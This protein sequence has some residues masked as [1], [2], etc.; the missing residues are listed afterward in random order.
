MGTSGAALVTPW[1]AEPKVNKLETHL[2]PALRHTGR[3][4]ETL[5]G[6]ALLVRGRTRGKD[7]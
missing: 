5:K 1:N 6:E 7:M 2:T 4:A 3:K